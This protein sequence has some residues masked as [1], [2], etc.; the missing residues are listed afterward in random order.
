MQKLHPPRQLEELTAKYPLAL[1]GPVWPSSAAPKPGM[2]G[3]S[4]NQRSKRQLWERVGEHGDL[5]ALLAQGWCQEER[6]QRKHQGSPGLG[7][8]TPISEAAN[9]APFTSTKYT[10]FKERRRKKKRKKKKGKKET[11]DKNNKGEKR[12]KKK[13]RWWALCGLGQTAI[14]PRVLAKVT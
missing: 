10:L 4:P 12:R 3:G 13:K 2:G 11:E 14:F 1:S 6:A 7:R 8:G 9:S 5:R